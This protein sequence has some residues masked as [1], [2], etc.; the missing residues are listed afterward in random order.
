MAELHQSL[1][2]LEAD[3]E[4]LRSRL[5]AVSQEKLSQEQDGS[6]L[7]RKLQEAE[8]KVGRKRERSAAASVAEETR[9]PL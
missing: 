4:L 7:Q 2:S 3:S 6:Q 1:L 5:N 8:K 9:T